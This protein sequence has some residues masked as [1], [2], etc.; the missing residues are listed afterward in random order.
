M[1]FTREIVVREEEKGTRIDKLLS[2]LLSGISRAKWQDLIKEGLVEI[3][4]GRK[5]P[6]YQVKAGEG[7]RIKIPEDFDSTDLEP[8]DLPLEVIYED[9]YL[10]GI[11]KPSPMVV[12]PGPGHED[13]TLANALVYH[14]PDLPP[15]PDPAR[16]G[17]VHRLDKDTSGVLA[18]ARTESVY[19]NLKEQFK[20]RKVEKAYLALVEGGFEEGG[21][22]IDAPI[23]RSSKDKTKMTVKLG[24]K[25]S[26][27]EF[28]VLEAFED[29]SLLEVKPRTG[30]THQIRVHMDYIGHRIVGDSYYG[31]RDC[32]RLMLHSKSLTFEHPETGEE[33]TLEAS[34][35][36]P[37]KELTGEGS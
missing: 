6:S 10:L 18:I 3:D 1:A 35:P 14:Y 24:G 17:I 32:E 31:G 7:I 30:R 2:R 16:P 11:D 5:K 13:D 20:E 4:G 22:M 37:F 21:G 26:Q 36:D 8:Q 25:E 9:D 15:V 34:I 19:D 33:V 23:G 12:H 28:R 29:S 27:T